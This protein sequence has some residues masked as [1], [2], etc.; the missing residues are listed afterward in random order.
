MGEPRVMGIRFCFALK[1][2]SCTV[3]PLDARNQQIDGANSAKLSLS[4]PP[5]IRNLMKSDG[6]SVLSLLNW[7]HWFK[8]C[9]PKLVL[10]ACLSSLAPVQFSLVQL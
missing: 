5:Q 7:L 9:T 8:K 4:K 6:R 1:F 2:A 10:R 3:L